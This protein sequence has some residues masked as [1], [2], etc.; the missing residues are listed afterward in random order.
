MSYEDEPLENRL[1][2]LAYRLINMGMGFVEKTYGLGGLQESLK[3]FVAAGV[4][5]SIGKKTKL[6]NEFRLLGEML[7]KKGG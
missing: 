7:F 3:P 6:P 1:D 5:E 2:V 4:K